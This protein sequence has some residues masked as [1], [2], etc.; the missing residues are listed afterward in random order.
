[1][2]PEFPEIPEPNSCASE[3][4][5]STDQLRA[6]LGAHLPRIPCRKKLRKWHQDGMPWIS[7]PNSPQRLFLLSAV[8]AWLHSRMRSINIHQSAVDHAFLAS[9]RKCRKPG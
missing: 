4:L 8:L 9:R 2:S 3:P 7:L 6:A 1:M 5:L